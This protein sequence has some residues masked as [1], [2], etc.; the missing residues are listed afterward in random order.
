MKRLLTAFAICAAVLVS[1]G[2]TPTPAAADG[3]R[4]DA[5]RHAGPSDRQM[6]WYYANRAEP[7]WAFRRDRDRRNN[8]FRRHRHGRGY[9]YR[10]VPPRHRHG[11]RPGPAYA[12]QLDGARFIFRFD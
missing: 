7:R 8:K 12:L 4:H 2:A 5:R 1:A 6:S 3:G 9:G 10:Y 11:Y